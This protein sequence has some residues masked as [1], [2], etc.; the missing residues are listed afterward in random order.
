MASRKVLR[1]EGARREAIRFV[2][3]LERAAEGLGSELA[4]E[5]LVRAADIV[6]G[7]LGDD[8]GA[9]RILRAATERDPY[10][11]SALWRL[12]ELA[13]Q[14]GDWGE[15]DRLL[16]LA[17]SATHRVEP[18]SALLLLR[19]DVLFERLQR[20]LEARELYLHVLQSSAK[21]E[22][23]T[24]AESRLAQVDR[25]LRGEGVVEP[26]EL[27]PWPPLGDEPSTQL[28]GDKNLTGTDSIVLLA[29]ELFSKGDER[30]AARDLRAAEFLVS[31]GLEIAPEHELGKMLKEKV[32]AEKARAA[33]RQ[34]TDEVA[35]DLRKR[36]QAGDKDAALD[37]LDLERGHIPGNAY[38]RILA[39]GGELLLRVGSTA[40]SLESFSRARA[41][42]PEGRVAQDALLGL[43]GAYER[44]GHKKDAADALV[45]LGATGDGDLAARIGVLYAESGA[46]EEARA[47]LGTAMG[48]EPS[49]RLGEHLLTLC[50]DAGDVEGAL[51]LKEQLSGEAG[52][53]T[54]ERA[55]FGVR[56][57]MAVGRHEDAK[58][59][60]ESW[61]GRRTPSVRFA[62]QCF[63]LGRAMADRKLMVH[64]A[65]ALCHAALCSGQRNESFLSSGLLHAWSEADSDE[66]LEYTSTRVS[67]RLRPRLPLPSSWLLE[68]FQKMRYGHAVSSQR[69]PPTM[70]RTPKQSPLLS[71][72]FESALE[73]AE[74]LF[75]LPN[76]QVAFDESPE[77]TLAFGDK[78]MIVA[79]KTA[80][81]LTPWILRFCVGRAAALLKERSLA[82]RVQ[83]RAFVTVPSSGG[84]AYMLDAA[85]LVLAQDLAS[86][87]AYVGLRGPRALSLASFAL[88]NALPRLWRT[89]GLGIPQTSMRGRVSS[90]GLAPESPAL[91]ARPDSQG[92]RP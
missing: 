27:L 78:P 59:D 49:T 1:H 7:S 16:G 14:A 37:L 51:R 82:S 15:L 35:R 47:W 52:P 2:E 57:Q 48:L 31:A 81:H 91:G 60:A 50:L 58:C 29:D 38:A 90:E 46:A 66:E 24:R 62:R 18:R 84:R 22:Y 75:D 8:I 68:Q 26:A 10:C 55:L 74:L 53:E 39:L 36:I 56:V 34:L 23:R 21:E 71:E 19:G 44:L 30:L 79:P 43:A 70:K 45:L 33:S 20:P 32:E 72:V 61:L 73:A 76:I 25:V 65:K 5:L 86:V 83:G 9:L 17:A 88:S 87:L 77:W 11:R 6:R 41:C 67:L 13:T 3:K 12:G 42:A 92:A 28:V 85:G 4:A 40:E 64:S 54:E 63:E 80:Q 89:T 69:K